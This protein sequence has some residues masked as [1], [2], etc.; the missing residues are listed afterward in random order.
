M[1]V[2]VHVRICKSLGRMCAYLVNQQ[3]M[4]PRTHHAF[5][6]ALLLV[7]PIMEVASER[8]NWKMKEQFHNTTRKSIISALRYW[9]CHEGLC[10]C[11][12]VG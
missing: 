9:P 7:Q 6:C 3:K 8:A 12:Y 4:F 11:S 10:G 5:Y 2:K 1:Y